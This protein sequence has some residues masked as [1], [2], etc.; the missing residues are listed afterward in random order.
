MGGRNQDSVVFAAFFA[1]FGAKML[2]FGQREYWTL[3]NTA[4]LFKMVFPL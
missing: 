2:F 1:L 4:N 3:Q